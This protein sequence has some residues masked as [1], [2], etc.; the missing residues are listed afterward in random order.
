MARIPAHDPYHHERPLHFTSHPTALLTIS[1]LLLAR[2]ACQNIHG[3]LAS[4]IFV[5]C[6]LRWIRALYLVWHGV[7]RTMYS[8]ART[9]DSEVFLFF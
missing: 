3:P 7:V 2:F 5:S 6:S 1:F 8:L 9:L 4:S